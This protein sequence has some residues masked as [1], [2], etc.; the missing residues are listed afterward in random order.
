MPHPPSPAS[1]SPSPPRRY[2]RHRVPFE[3]ADW[4]GLTL[5]E[6]S[7][8]V[9]RLLAQREEA[10]REPAKARLRRE[11]LEEL[12]EGRFQG[13]EERVEEVARDRGVVGG[14]RGI[15]GR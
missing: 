14:I 6:A 5:G 15:F 11:L 9:T 3:E 12:R 1:C 8:K 4:H 2:G 13:E 10:A 7:L